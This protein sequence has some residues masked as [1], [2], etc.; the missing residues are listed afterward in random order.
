MCSQS[1][2]WAQSAALALKGLGLVA[3]MGAAAA[4]QLCLDEGVGG[5]LEYLANTMVAN[6]LPRIRN[7]AHHAMDALFDSLTARTSAAPGVPDAQ[8]SDQQPSALTRKAQALVHAIVRWAPAAL[9]FRG[10]C[11]WCTAAHG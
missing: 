3:A 10:S 6:P 7:A 4:K 9:F 8:V 11:R 2:A 1:Y 5:L